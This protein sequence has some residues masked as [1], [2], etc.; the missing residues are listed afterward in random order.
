MPSGCCFSARLPWGACSRCARSTDRRRSSPRWST[1]AR[2]IPRSPPAGQGTARSVEWRSSPGRMPLAPP[3]LPPGAWPQPRRRVVSRAEPIAPARVLP[4][5][6]LQANVY[7]DDSGV[8]RRGRARAVPSLGH[9]SAV[10][11]IRSS[12]PPLPWDASTYRVAFLPAKR[13]TLQPGTVGGWSSPSVPGRRWCCRPPPSW[14]G[15][16]GPAVLAVDQDGQPLRRIPISVG[17]SPY[18]LTMVLSGLRPTER[19]LVRGA[20]FVDASQHLGSP[21]PAER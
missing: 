9:S 21:G 3:T 16:D 15:P 19:I 14:Q 6:T 11:V 17:R 7:D 4:D 5:G 8:S 10:D 1:P 20:F 18:G 2:C 12:V 13:G